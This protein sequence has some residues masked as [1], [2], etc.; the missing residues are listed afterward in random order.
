VR[1]WGA[2]VS[3]QE[4]GVDALQARPPEGLDDVL[5]VASGARHSCVALRGGSVV[6]FG[7]NS[8][9][10]APHAGAF[11]PTSVRALSAGFYNTCATLADNSVRCLGS[12]TLSGKNF[13]HFEQ[14]LDKSGMQWV[15]A[16]AFHSCGIAA[17]TG[18][19]SCWGVQN[20]DSAYYGRG[21]SVAPSSI[22]VP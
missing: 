3:A 9:G 15:S 16:G 22:F 20:L 10:Q 2:G 5:F 1:C 6:C 21:Q 14:S 13:P 4:T 8:H 7:Q 11:F 18:A 17:G 19:I 12:G